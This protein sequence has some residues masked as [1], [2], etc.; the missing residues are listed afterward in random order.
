ML[1]RILDYFL[2]PQNG[3]LGIIVACLIFLLVWQQRRLDKKDE[4][5]GTL[6]D[7][8]ETLLDSYAKSQ[9]DVVKEVVGTSKDSTSAVNLMQRSIDSLT[10]SFQA[11]INGRNKT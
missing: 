8:I 4:I 11:F 2:Q 3:I 9:T 6:R 1:E 7:K 5:I 10:T